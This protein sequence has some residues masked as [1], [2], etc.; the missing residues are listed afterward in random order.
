MK[1]ESLDRM[2]TYRDRI[3]ENCGK[4]FMMMSQDWAYRGWRKKLPI[5]FCT[6]K[7]MRAY[8]QKHPKN[9]AAER[10]RIIQA[11]NDGLS[12]KE[13]RDMLCVDVEKVKYVKNKLEGRKDA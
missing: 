1:Q 7:C 9:L 3:C 5:Y 11:L 2:F 6:W 13:I 12:V 8:E 10:E 4:Q